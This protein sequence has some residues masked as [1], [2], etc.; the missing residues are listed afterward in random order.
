M[1][2]GQ[3]TLKIND[4]LDVFAVHG[5]GDIF[6]IVMLAVFGHAGWTEQL[7]AWPLLGSG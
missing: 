5:V 4:T 1:R 7:G 6:G 3:N 2:H